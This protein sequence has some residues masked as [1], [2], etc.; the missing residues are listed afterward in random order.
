M[1]RLAVAL[2]AL[3]LL[4][5]C[6]SD[7]HEFAGLTVEPLPQVGDVTLPDLANGGAPFTMRAPDGGLLL[8]YFG[9][10]NC[11]FECP[12]TL[13]DVSLIERALAVDDPGID[14]RIELAMVTVDPARDLPVLADYVTGFV[15]DGHALGTDDDTVLRAAADA[16][17]VSY[18]V[19]GE[20]VAHST[21]LYAV[22]D[23]GANVMVWTFPTDR[24]ALQA[25]IKALLAQS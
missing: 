3:G 7:P 5:G 12:T 23:T 24:D 19:A 13:G 17:L 18:Q 22:D 6:G 8:V 4:A 1:K 20:Q 15:A 9:Y 14:Q 11:P 2:A 10:T 16:F 21:H 25:D